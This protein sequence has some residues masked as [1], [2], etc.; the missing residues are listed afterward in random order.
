M[1]NPRLFWWWRQVNWV[2]KPKHKESCVMKT[3]QYTMIKLHCCRILKHILV[4]WFYCHD[5]IRNPF[6]SHFGEGVVDQPCIQSSNEGSWLA[7]QY[8]YFRL[9]I[10]RLMTGH[11]SNKPIVLKRLTDFPAT[12]YIV[13]HQKFSFWFWNK[14]N[15][16]TSV[17]SIV[18]RPTLSVSQLIYF[19]I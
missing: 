13:Q 12:T 3:H 14:S 17:N 2:Y 4:L 1:V 10:F 7:K 9:E 11:S 19:Y 15:H 5:V 8:K 16:T 6:I 18:Q